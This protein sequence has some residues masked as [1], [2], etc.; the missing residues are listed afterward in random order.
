MIRYRCEMN[1]PADRGL[2][3]RYLRANSPQEAMEMCKQLYGAS[4]RPTITRDECQI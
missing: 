1:T 3:A 4:V 2:I